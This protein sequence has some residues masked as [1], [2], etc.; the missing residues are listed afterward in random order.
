MASTHGAGD[1]VRR[2][3]RRAWRARPPGE[4]RMRTVISVTSAS[5][6]SLPVSK[7][8]PVVAGG[9]EMG[10]ADVEDFAVDRDDLQAQQVV[11][12]DAVFQAMRAARVHVDVAA[13]HA[14]ELAGRIGRV[15]EAFVGDRVGD[16]DIGHPGLHGR[17]TIGVV[18]VED[19]V[20]PHHADDDGVGHRQ[21]AAGQRGA[22][23]TRHHAHPVGV[24]EAHD[25]RDLL[26][27]FRQRDG[28]RHLAIGGQP[29]GLVWPEADRIGDDTLRVGDRRAQAGDHRVTPRHHIG[30]RVGQS[31]HERASIIHDGASPATGQAPGEPRDRHERPPPGLVTAR[32]RP[33]APRKDRAPT[34]P[35]RR[36]AARSAPFR[37]RRGCPTHK[38]ATP[39]R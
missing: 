2:E 1:F 29:V 8:E 36:T 18:D 27:G 6:P 34:R 10:A 25:R 9:V 31:D 15:E 32:A 4:R 5:W 3:I 39:D 17:A 16:A 19:L 13:D 38:L 22:R 26:G 7:P 21:R 23:A 30:F 33:G 24:A 35:R 28:E 14:G 20:H 37:S 12:G 11:R